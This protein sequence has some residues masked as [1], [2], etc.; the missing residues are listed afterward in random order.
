VR[1]FDFRLSTSDI[2]YAWRTMSLRSPESLG[3]SSTLMRVWKALGKPPC[4]LAGGFLRDHLLGRSSRDLDLSLLGTADGVAAPARR[5]ARELGTRAHLLGQPPRCVWRIEGE[6]LKVELWPLGGLTLDEDIL[7]RD[8]SCNALMWQLPSGPLVD[9]VGGLRDLQHGRLRAISADNLDRDPVRLLRGPRFLATYQGFDIDEQTARWIRRLAPRLA[10]SP[11]ERVGQELLL[12]L[13]GERPSRG[14]AAIADLELLT[15]AAPRGARVD[16]SWLRASLPAANCLSSTSRHPIPSALRQAGDGA[17]LGYLFRAMGSPSAEATAEYA[18]VR[19]C[20]RAAARAVRLIDGAG[21]VAAGV[22]A[23]R[24]EMIHLAGPAFPALVAMGSALAHSSGES[25]VDWHRWWRQWRR[26]GDDLVAPRQLVTAEEIGVLVGV[27]PGPG[28]G[29][30]IRELRH[31][32]IRGEIRTPA[33]ARRWLRA[34][35]GQ[36]VS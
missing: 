27:D 14:L 36:A 15:P 10:E 7:R 16:L 1:V 18:W 23:E 29:R 32:Q 25:L 6:D 31:A 12:L 30:I 9:R 22:P 20:R 11:R 3:R 26:S 19:D 35:T 13:R 8:F 33:G 21:T 2:R 5:L 17:R 34:R 4:H 24:R 28:L